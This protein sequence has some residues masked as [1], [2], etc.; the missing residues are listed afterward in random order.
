M[1]RALATATA[2]ASLALWGPGSRRQPPL[3]CEMPRDISDELSRVLR[4]TRGEEGEPSPFESLIARY[5]YMDVGVMLVDG[6]ACVSCQLRV[7][8]IESWRRLPGPNVAEGDTRGF[9]LAW[10]LY[11]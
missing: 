3:A 10:R 2:A 8:L 7:P 9:F 4:E 6:C 11:H 1:R 5:A